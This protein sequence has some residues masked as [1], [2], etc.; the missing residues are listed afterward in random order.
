MPF[1]VFKIL[2]FI[3]RRI[4]SKMDIVPQ[5]L[6]QLAL[7]L[8]NAIFA[9]AEIAVLSFNEA[10][11]TQMADGG[12]KKAKKLVKLTARPAKFLATIQ[13]AITLS[14]FLGS[15]FAADNFSDKLVG[16]LSPLVGNVISPAVLDKI[17]V[18]VI[19]LVLSYFTLIFGEL[20]PKRLA[21][22]NSEKISLALAS[23]ISFISTVF[24][25]IVWFL[26]VSTNGVLRLFGIDPNQKDDEV[27]EEEIKLM[28]DVG[29]ENGAIDIDEKEIIQNVFEFDD[30][31]AEELSTRRTDVCVLWTEQT[32]AEWEA[33]IVDSK[34]TKFPICDETIDNV[35][36]V[37]NAKDYFRLADKSRENVMKKAAKTPYFVP[38]SVKAD[39][40]FKNMKESRDFFAVVLDEYGGMSGIVTLTD[41]LRCLVGDYNDDEGEYEETIPDIVKLEDNRWEILG[42]AEISEVSDALGIELEDEDCDTFA[43]YILSLLGTIP[44]DG[45]TPD[46]ET[47]RLII[48]VTE[49]AEHRIEKA[50]VTLKHVE[51]EE[52]EE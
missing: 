39:V 52:E 19:T 2:L 14:G 33:V 25:P 8:L 31:T 9:C 48:N 51:E 50:L 24:A 12:N 7:I 45:S 18:I 29:S 3:F 46:V 17:C 23:I 40:L 27:T 26:T 43:G 32:D 20:V 44:E 37:L 28:V 34:Y 49:V 35:V 15:A 36:A 6:L 10:K 42:Q 47:D 1:G 22:K 41:L 5:L 13:V 38:E 16:L 4:L 21:M 30:L 11:L